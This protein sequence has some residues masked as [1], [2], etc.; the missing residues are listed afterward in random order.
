MLTLLLSSSSQVEEYGAQPPIELLRQFMD[1]GGWYD[2]KELLFRKLVDIQFVAAMG[3]PGGGRNGVT[4]RYLRH[5]SVV[6]VTQF[7]N[8]NLT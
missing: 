3:P 5:Y 1:H 8:E 6:S 4:N 2:R 7:D